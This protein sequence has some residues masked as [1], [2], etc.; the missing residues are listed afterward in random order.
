M[1]KRLHNRLIP[2]LVSLLVLLASAPAFASQLFDLGA[3]IV[4]QDVNNFGTVVGW[5]NNA[6]GL[7][8]AFRYSTATGQISDL[9]GTAAY[10]VND[11]DQI[12]GNTLVGA[13]LQQGNSLKSWDGASA[14][15]LSETGLVAGA[16]VGFNIYRPSPVP[17][18]PAAFD[19]HKWTKID[20]AQVYPRGSRL[21]VY[22]DLYLLADVNDQGYAVGSRRRSGLAGSSAIMIVPPYSAVKLASDVIYL[23]TSGG[24]AAA[25]NNSNL[26]VG[27]T[28]TNQAY[29]YDGTT[30][31]L[32]GTL[33]GGL[34]S[35]AA[36]INEASTVVGSSGTASGYHA[37][38]KP[39]GAAMQDLNDL[40]GLTGW[41]LA[42]ATAINELGDIVGTG[43]FNGQPH[44]FLLVNG[45]AAPAPLLQPLAIQPAPTPAPQ[46][47]LTPTV[48]PVPTTTST[49]AS[50]PPV[51]VVKAEHTSGKIPL[52]V[53]FKGSK[54]YDPE[55]SALSYH[56]DFGDGT[57][58]T[59]GDPQHIYTRTGNFL[60]VLTVTDTS[61]L[62]AQGIPVEIAAT[63]R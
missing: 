34:Y 21:G 30:V 22:A 5:Y 12:A 15:G 54:S 10:A 61:N 38:V 19:G 24:S 27:T 3:G 43:T 46:P 53:S 23:P 56:W 39:Y 58:S 29:L 36:D 59:S 7:R 55:G 9:G 32:L 44:G 4:P 57:T 20:I 1:T 48:D 28:G 11:A 16:Q 33:P 51:A 41:V 25:I 47:G 37:F 62:S 31:S 49:T 8:T 2:L 6:Q 52:E 45:N 17:Y 13:F 26:V 50:Q 63:V 35:S 14:Y 18:N 42:S 40:V 60:A